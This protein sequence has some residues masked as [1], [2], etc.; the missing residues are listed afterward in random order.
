MGFGVF[1]GGKTGQLD[2]HCFSLMLVGGRSEV[3]GVDGGGEFAFGLALIGLR[4]VGVEVD[5][6]RLTLPGSFLFR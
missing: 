1:L 4:A 5:L 6:I 3:L 2:Y